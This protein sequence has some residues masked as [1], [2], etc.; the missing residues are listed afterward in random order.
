MSNLMMEWYNNVGIISKEMN[1]MFNR[2]GW[3][4]SGFAEIMIFNS[5]LYNI[6]MFQIRGMDKF[7]PTLFPI[8]CFSKT[9]D[10]IKKEYPNINYGTKDFILTIG[11]TQYTIRIVNREDITPEDI[12]IYPNNINVISSFKCF[13]LIE[14]YIKT[15]HNISNDNF[16][17]ICS[18]YRMKFFN[19]CMYGQ[20]K[21]IIEKTNKSF[22]VNKKKELEDQLHKINTELNNLNTTN[23]THEYTEMTTPTVVTPTVVVSLKAVMPMLG[24]TSVGPKAVKTKV[25]PN[26][27]APSVVAPKVVAPS[28][29]TPKVVAPT[30]AV[31]A[32]RFSHNSEKQNAKLNS[33]R[34]NIIDPATLPTPSLICPDIPSDKSSEESDNSSEEPDAKKRR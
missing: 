24:E 28:V 19:V 10:Q 1:R 9:L 11:V 15:P 2:N 32:S 26:V 27:V 20:Y 30:D 25:T 16:E 18:Y 6:P 21:L 3:A 34:K 23:S 17:D 22:L 4:L 33:I 14:N 29:V 13:K 5:M 7:S 31:V 12:V 8:Q